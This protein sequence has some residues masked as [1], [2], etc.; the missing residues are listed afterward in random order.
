ME[1]GVAKSAATRL[2]LA[3]GSEIRRS[4]LTG[5]GIAFDVQKPGVDEDIIKA[6][7]RALGEPLADTA[8]ALAS[9]K[10]MAID[11]PDDAYVL[12][13]DQIMEFDGS[14]YDKPAS[15][16]EAARR[17]AMLAGKTHRLINGVAI[18]RGRQLVFRHIDT[19]SLTMHDLSDTQIADYLH[20]A[21]PD[22][23]SSV[24]AYQVENI[25]MRLFRKIDGDF[26]TTLGLSIFP[27]MTF[28]RDEG[29]LPF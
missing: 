22:I 17:L 21:G 20:A 29:F 7:G 23:L 6:K 2:I 16:D 18:T 12:G 27:V 10:A 1:N 3:S 19:V 24:G 13:S 8:F 25:G 26:Y 28:L 9:A 14:G 5:A 4:I 15:M 11:A